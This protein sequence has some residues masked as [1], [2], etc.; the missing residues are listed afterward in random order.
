MKKDALRVLGQLDE[1]HRTLWNELCRALQK[2]EETTELSAKLR[3]L[4][5]LKWQIQEQ[6]RGFSKSKLPWQRAGAFFIK[7][8]ALPYAELHKAVTDILTHRE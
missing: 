8:H 7:S 5:E 1:I 4:D 6:A 3:L 2:T